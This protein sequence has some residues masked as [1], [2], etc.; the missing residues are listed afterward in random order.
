MVVTKKVTKDPYKDVLKQIL[1]EVAE[2]RQKIEINANKRLQKY[3][4]NYPSGLFSKSACNLAYYLAM[5]QF[6]LRHL[7][8]RLAQA[9]MVQRDLCEYLLLRNRGTNRDRAELVGIESNPHLRL[10][11]RLDQ[12]RGLDSSRRCYFVAIER[13]RTCVAMLD[14]KSVV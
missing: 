4:S 12:L 10:T 6:D 9:G 2:L 1:A 5:R 8:D 3:Q 7:Q 11:H 14:R 13:T